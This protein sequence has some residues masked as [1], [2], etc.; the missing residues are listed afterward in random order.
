MKSF[1]SINY[2][3]K[4][5]E[6]YTICITCQV[7]FSFIYICNA[8]PEYLEE[9]EECEKAAPR[10][11]LE[12]GRGRRKPY[13]RVKYVGKRCCFSSSSS[14]FLL[15]RSLKYSYSNYD[16]PSSVSLLPSFI[17]IACIEEEQDPKKIYLYRQCGHYG[18]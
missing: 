6:E 18:M 16:L 9:K 17:S 14:F 4:V 3:P 10:H 15:L 7:S 12:S 13:L 11:L 8:Q 1:A 2:H 5:N